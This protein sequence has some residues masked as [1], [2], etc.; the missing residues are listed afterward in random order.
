[1]ASPW[2]NNIEPCWTH[3]KKAVMEPDRK[4]TALEI[5]SRVCDHFSCK[6]LPYFKSR[7]AAVSD[8]SASL[9]LDCEQL[10]KKK[11]KVTN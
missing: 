6:F 1:V 3:A 2:L 10:H 8:Q 9:P 11:P 5:T 4:L 7:V